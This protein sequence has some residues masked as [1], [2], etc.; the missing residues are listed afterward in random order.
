MK[1]WGHFWSHGLSEL[2]AQAETHPKRDQAADR[3]RPPP[4]EG[5][6]KGETKTE[7]TDWW[8]AREAM[9]KEMQARESTIINTDET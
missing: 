8:W 9:L 2:A 1:A 7:E 5:A 6:Y 3:A 4:Y